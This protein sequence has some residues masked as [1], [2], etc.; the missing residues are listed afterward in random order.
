LGVFDAEKCAAIRKNWADPYLQ[1]ASPFHALVT[2]S[3][4]V[5]ANQLPRQRE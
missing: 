2:I 5:M 3:H 4:I 1:Y